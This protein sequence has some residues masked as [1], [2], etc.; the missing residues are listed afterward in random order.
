MDMKRRTV[1]GA[2][3][4]FAAGGSSAQASGTILVPVG[5]GSQSDTIARR[6]AALLAGTT[7]A[8]FIV[9]NLPGAGGV[10]AGR[11]LLNR[12]ADGRTLLLAT[13]GAICNTPLLAKPPLDFDPPTDYAPVGTF[14]HTPFVLFAGKDFAAGTLAELQDFGQKQ[15]HPLSYATVDAGSANHVAGETLLR[16][17]GLRG[18]HVPYRNLAQAAQDISE[19]RVQLGVLVWSFVAPLVR[20][21]KVKILSVLS[22]RPLPVDPALPT[23]ASQGFGA[24]DVQ[25][26]YGLFV[27]ASSPPA[28]I[29]EQEKQLQS[30]IANKGYSDFLTQLGQD[31]QFRGHAEAKA[32]VSSE[33]ARYRQVL[34]QLGLT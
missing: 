13:S 10:V 17:L 9:E 2:I 30:A 1:L 31:V 15:A 4:G 28:M 26:W 25:G 24:F 21:G 3:A 27:A 33:V 19:G 20:A 12:P 7:R 22:S 34:Q 11:Q 5:A 18:T 32:F 16:R 14:A 23:V 8:S 29:A 6:Y